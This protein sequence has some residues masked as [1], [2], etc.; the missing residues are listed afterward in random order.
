M[1][2]VDYSAQVPD[3]WHEI[4]D[5]VPDPEVETTTKQT[6]YFYQICQMLLD[7]GRLTRCRTIYVLRLVELITAGIPANPAPGQVDNYLQLTAALCH[8]LQ[9]DQADIQRAGV[10]VLLPP[11]TTA[12]TPPERG[13]LM[14]PGEY[15]AWK[16]YQ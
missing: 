7:A 4:L 2:D 6:Q 1:I 16:L 11:E 13:R 10:P 5:A 15:E 8:Q 9:L 12:T 14:Q 3:S